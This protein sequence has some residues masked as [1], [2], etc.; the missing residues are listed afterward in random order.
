MAASFQWISQTG[1]SIRES[2][3]S[4]LPRTMML[5]LHGFGESSSMEYGILRHFALDTFFLVV[6][7]FSA[8]FLTLFFLFIV[9]SFIC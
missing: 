8:V 1:I 9:T 6:G 2:F 3:G 7:F 4:F 5:M